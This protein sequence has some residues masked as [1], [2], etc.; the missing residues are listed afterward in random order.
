[1]CHLNALNMTLLDSC[2][3]AM[4]MRMNRKGE[5][6]SPCLIP[7]EGENVP[8]GDPLRRIEKKVEETKDKIHLIQ[9]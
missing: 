6:G 7:L 1:M 2:F 8:V 3:E 4:P 5:R 9:A